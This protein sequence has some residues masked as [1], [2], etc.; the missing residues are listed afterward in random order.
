MADKKTY[1]NLKFAAR[2]SQMPS[3]AEPNVTYLELKFKPVPEPRIPTGNLSTTYSE[4]KFR[5]PDPSVDEGFPTSS[6][7]GD[8]PAP[9]RTDPQTQELKENVGSGSSWRIWLLGLVTLA[10]IATVV[11][12]SVYVFQTYQS[13]V[14]CE[15]NHWRLSKQ[16]QEPNKT[17]RQYPQQIHELNSTF[18]S[19]TS[20]YI[21][22]SRKNLSALNSQLSVLKRRNEDLL[23]QFN[24]METK[25]KTVNETKARICELLTSRTEETCSQG[26][27][28]RT[29]ACYFIS[30]VAKS[31][32]EAK[33]ECS[34]NASTLLEIS[35]MAEEKFVV[36][37]VN[38]NGYYWIG[39]CLGS[40]TAECSLLYKMVEPVCKSCASDSAPAVCSGENY[41]ICK[42]PAIPSETWGLCQNSPGPN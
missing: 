4:L 23:Q 19:G 25:F 2:G 40:G 30:T 22:L 33:Q 3:R 16:D 12:L 14:I 15:R 31:H 32:A 34:N 20:E 10:L 17:Q 24:V 11:G 13:L 9:C 36:N 1:A 39:K 8:R 42:K 27:V 26:W 29:G 5:N 18:E 21:Q 6:G 28:N 41:F 38:G 37:T 35:S 7:G